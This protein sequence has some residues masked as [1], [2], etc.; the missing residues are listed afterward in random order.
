MMPSWKRRLFVRVNLNRV[1]EEGKFTYEI[2]SNYS[3]LTA[4]KTQEV[5]SEINV[6]LES[7]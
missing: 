6:S 2:L 4:K 5:K 1:N 3:Y 7:K